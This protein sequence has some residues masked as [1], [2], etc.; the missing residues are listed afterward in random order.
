MATS[1]SG[2]LKIMAGAVKPEYG[3]L[4]LLERGGFYE[5]VSQPFDLYDFTERVCPARSP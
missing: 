2:S 4:R 3:A 5:C 1:E